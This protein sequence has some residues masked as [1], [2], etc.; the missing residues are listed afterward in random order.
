MNSGFEDD[1]AFARM[2][3]LIDVVRGNV[4]PKKW[5]VLDTEMKNMYLEEAKVATYVITT[6][7]VDNIESFMN[8]VEDK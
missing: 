7:D 8:L 1:L 6:D 3:Y 5:W 4:P 2:N